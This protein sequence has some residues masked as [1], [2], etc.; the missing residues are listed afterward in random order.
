MPPRCSLPQNLRFGPSKHTV[1]DQGK[2]CADAFTQW[3]SSCRCVLA[4]G[5]DQRTLDNMAGSS[6]QPP[7]FPD[8]AGLYNPSAA[9]LIDLFLSSTEDARG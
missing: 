7:P 3:L 4:G 9:Y 5:N 2:H 8:K 1:L 6:R